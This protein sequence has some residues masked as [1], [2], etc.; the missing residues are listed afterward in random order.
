TVAPSAI[1]FNDSD[2]VPHELELSEI[3]RLI[4]SFV[5][6]A[7]R[8]KEAGFEVIEIHAAHGYLLHSFLSP[9]SNRRTDEY[10]GS[11]RNRTRFLVNTAQAIR[12]VWPKEFPLF[13]RLSATDWAEGGWTLEDSVEVSSELKIAGANLIDCSSGGLVPWAKIPVGPGYQVP[14]AK[15]IREKAGIATG[16]VGMIT[17]AEQANSIVT[18]GEADLVLLAREFLRDAYWPI[19]AARALGHEI[20]APVQYSRAW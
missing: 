3:D 6:A 18:S 19:H 15:R 17:D 12:T 5:D 4:R 9:L 11:F 20:E 8:A 1:P 7:K 2:P 13:V 16:A 10:G 14:F